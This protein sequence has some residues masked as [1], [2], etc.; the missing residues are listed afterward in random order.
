M[1]KIITVKGAVQGV[2]YRPFIAGIATEYNL[3]GYVKNTGDCVEILVLGADEDIDAFCDRIKSDGPK[4]S[5]VV[6]VL[7]KDHEEVPFDSFEIIESEDIDLSRELPIFLP[8]I[9][10]CSDCMEE[11]L[12][13][14]NRRYGYP[15]ISCAVCGPRLSILD[16]FPYDRDNTAMKPFK[17][18]SKCASE[19]KTGRRRHAQTISCFDCGPQLILK[20]PDG[21][22]LDPETSIDSAKELI[23]KDGIIGLKGVSGYQLVCKSSSKAAGR[24]RLLKGRENKPF[25]MMFSTIY[26][27]KKYCYVSSLEEEL[28]TSFARPIVLLKKKADVPKEV[29]GDSAYIGAFLPSMGA[30]RLLCDDLGPLIVTS[31]NI[32]GS[33]IITDD[34]EFDSIFLNKEDHVDGVLCHE[35]RINMPQD[36]SVLFVTD[37]KKKETYQFIRRSRGYAPLPVFLDEK[38]AVNTKSVLAFGGDLK[39]TFSIGK[40][41]RI[42]TSQFIG[43]LEDAGTFENY[44]RLLRDYLRLFETVPD[45]IVSDR[46]PGYHSTKL[47]AEYSGEHNTE[48]I[49]VQHHHA[50]ILSVMA[51]NSLDSCI[52]VSFDGTGFGDDGKIWGGEFLYCTGPNMLRKGHLSYVKLCGGDNAPKKAHIV[53]D[54][55]L[56]AA[57]CSK[58]KASAESIVKAA[59]LNNINTFETSSAGRLFD[60]VSSLLGIKDENSY[61]GECAILLEQEAMAYLDS[62]DHGETDNKLSFEINALD[63]A[64][65]LDQVKLFWD[66]Y[67]LKEAGVSIPCIAYLFH[68]ALSSAIA[69]VCDKIRLET[70]ENKVCLSGGVF[71]NR[72]LLKKS[73]ELLLDKGFEVYWNM[74]LP[75]GDGG[76]SAGQA[77]FVTLQELENN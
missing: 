54:C 19:Y 70:G 29:I 6:S 26:E 35:R 16:V 57:A 32:S 46:H 24:L 17:M 74:K 75:L 55:Y 22:Q 28:L 68:M 34:E 71:N 36:D 38:T 3:K 20:Y 63:G 60:A 44:N 49:T 59:L 66:I 21:K 42:I 25:T 27:I 7:I 67:L 23:K 31:A 77:Y 41:D 14:G 13:K 58:V 15:L 73:S 53:R 69:D 9:G 30:H 18:C 56:E 48:Y 43:D 50:H 40:K 1:A 61:E 76:I 45:I 52:G 4:G 5:F 37:T 51:E 10:I 72:I 65:I 33:P 47:A 12:Y 39:S 11:M 64:Y 62:D 2:G 8:D